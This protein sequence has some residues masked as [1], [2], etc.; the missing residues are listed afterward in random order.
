MADDNKAKIDVNINL[1]GQ[2]RLAQVGDDIE[3]LGD[4]AKDAGAAGQAAASDIDKLA[5][6]TKEAGDASSAAATDIDKLGSEVTQ[7]GAAGQSAAADIDKLGT[8]AKD[9]GAAGKTAAAGIDQLGAE[10]KQAG[11]ASQAAAAGIDKM[12][13]EARDAGAA[14]RVAAGGLNQAAAS[15]RQTG[16]AAKAAADGIDQLGAEAQQAGPKLT[17]VQRAVADLKSQLA[18]LR[19]EAKSALAGAAGSIAAF[20]GAREF[21]SSAAAMEQL[22]AGLQAVSGSAEQANRDLEFVRAIA[23]RVGVDV[24]EAGRAFLGLAAATKGTAVEGEPTRQVFEAVASAMAKAGK[25]SAETNNALMALS[26]MAG[27]GTVQMEELRGQ[28]GEALPGAL[29]AAAKGMGIT[30]QD[31]VKLVESGQVAASDLFPALTKGLNDLYG[32]TPGAQTLSQELTNV[33]NAFTDLAADI[34]EAG[35]LSALK[36]G[37]EIAGAGLVL[38]NDTLVVTGKTLGALAGAVATMNFSG[39]KQA[40]A[41]IEQESRDK[42]LKAAQHNEVL[43]GYVAAMGDEATKAALAQQQLGT[44]T[45]AAGDQAAAAAPSWMKVGQAYADL[46]T[47]AQQQIEQSEK[48]VIARKAE[49]DASVQLAQAFGTEAQQRDAQATAAANNSKALTTLAQQRLQEVSLLQSQLVALQ[50]LGAEAIKQDP[51]KAKQIEDLQ[52]TIALRQADADKA[53]A[54][55]GAARVAAGAAQ[56]EAEAYRDNASRVNE[57]RDAYQQ[58]ANALAL[59]QQRKAAGKATT[60]ELTA[61]EIAAGQAARLYRDALDDQVRA[62]QAKASVQ[63]G[64]I[65]LEQASLRVSQEQWK[66]IAEV[67]R[68]RGDEEAA[69]QAENQVRQI[70]IELLELTA[71]AKRAEAEAQLASVQAQRAALEVSGQLTEAKRLEL[72]AV[73]LAAEVKLKEAEISSVTAQKLRDLGSAASDAGRKSSSSSSDHY[74]NADALNAVADAAERARRGVDEYG[75]ATDKA[76]KRIVAGSDLATRT[77]IVNF[78][79]NAGVEDDATARRIANEFADAQGNIPNISNPGQLKYGGDTISVALLRAAEKVTMSGL[80]MGGS[81]ANNSAP[82]STTTSVPVSTPASTQT[83]NLQIS[84]RDYGSVATDAA[85]A[86]SLEAFIRGLQE[87]AGRSA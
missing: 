19:G 82:T 36:T 12:G 58:A 35:A 25:S 10:A 85:G 17:L 47:K 28:L 80:Q 3:Q 65:S 77:G 81:R 63:Q 37:A 44:T 54:Q 68:A 7:A 40:F 21:V 33:K 52:K 75:F 41:D 83:I 22:R 48:S 23:S 46:L 55:A 32:S 24:T 74:K 13:T 16:Q 42:L 14:G 59:V 50:A 87:A 26:Q 70:E 72:D 66:A 56:A 34:G 60:E 62:I 4:S 53:V 86:A 39:L 29:N 27:K 6:A 51:Q 84:G 1:Q 20:F 5:T 61:A 71:Q 11:A 30:T 43:R 49:G 79:K 69:I 15:A 9:A 67:A 57:L 76:G 38:L 18:Q 2:E 73:K 78:L 45:Q 64:A 31:L 8:E